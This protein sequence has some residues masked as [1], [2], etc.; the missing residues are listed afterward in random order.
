MDNQP[1]PAIAS[2]DL[3]I[4]GPWP[5]QHPVDLHPLDQER[6]A[7]I[8]DLPDLPLLISPQIRSRLARSPSSVHTIETTGRNSTRR[9]ESPDPRPVEFSYVVDDERQDYSYRGYL[10]RPRMHAYIRAREIYAEVDG[11]FGGK[12]SSRLQNCRKNAWFVQHDTTGDIRVQSSRCKLRWCPICRDV[13]RMIVTSAVESWLREQKYPKML[14]FTL[15]HTDDELTTQIKKLYDSFRKIRKR[16]LLKRAIT[17]GIWFFQITFNQQ[18]EQWHPHIHCLI[19]GAFIPHGKLKS[20]WHKITGDSFIVDIRPVRDIESAS[21]EV[22]R[23]ATSPAD[24]TKT[25]LEHALDVYY[26]TRNRR[27]CG[28][29]GS[30]RGL[31]LKPTPLDDHD[32]W[33][34]VA[35]FYYVNVNKK[36]D[37]NCKAFWHCFKCGKP[38][39][40]PLVQDE[41]DVYREELAF[42]RETDPSPPLAFHTFMRLVEKNSSF[43]G[44]NN[45]AAHD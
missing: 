13:S 4:S 18:T 33:Y 10:L 19:A 38:Y 37:A 1:P 44:V 30:A 35:D 32:S 43:M 26:A 28:T 39:T 29:W 2:V 3:T 5:S 24:I 40:G 14:T 36:T 42:L 27:I 41:R 12:F 6:L 8:G 11:S 20:L 21:S 25:D 45:H 34:K 31:K 17:G 16:V 9:V 15:E 23:Y 7:L 22:A